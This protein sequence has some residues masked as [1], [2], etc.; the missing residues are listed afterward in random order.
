MRVIP[1]PTFDCTDIIGKV[2]DDTNANG[3]QDKGEKGLA[4]VRVVSAR[5]LIATTDKH[6]RYHLTCAVVPNETR[7][8]NYILISTTARCQAAIGSPARTRW[9]SARPAAR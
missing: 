5:G 2:F 3:Y 1:D 6:G 8:S 9:S 7:G 4:G